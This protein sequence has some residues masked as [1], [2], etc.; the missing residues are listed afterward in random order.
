MKKKYIII[1]I[2]VIICSLVVVFTTKKG[3]NKGK[4]NFQSIVWECSEIQTDS[5]KLKS[6]ISDYRIVP[7]EY[8]DNS[9][10]GNIDKVIV[11]DSLVFIMDSQVA[12]G[13]FVFDVRSGKFI[14]NIGDVGKGFGEYFRLYD[15]SIDSKNRYI[16][17]LCEKKRLLCY[18]FSGKC[19]SVKELPFL[20][21]NF[22]YLDDKFYFINEIPDE[23]NLYITDCDFHIL[24]S[25]FPNNVYGENYRRLIHPLQKTSDG[26]LYRR[27]LDQNIYMID[28]DNN[29][30]PLYTLNLGDD[31]L[32]VD[33]VKKMPRGQLKDLMSQGVCHI[34]YYTDGKDYSMALFFIKNVPYISIYNKKKNVTKTYEYSM[35]KND[36]MNLDFPLLEFVSSEKKFIAVL[37]NED[38]EALIENNLYDNNTYEQNDNP[39][40][41]IFQ[42]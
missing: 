28:R 34:K 27:F 25:E 23:N 1:S 29:I 22:E 33:M 42:Q 7:L 9:I 37:Y 30:Y 14:R 41:C 13:I 17:V 38:I 19:L 12:A 32:S 35:M 36:L 15:M 2:L 21:T 39:M 18:S 5:F 26:I 24:S 11:A 8:T 31:Q 40:L 4:T 3:N 10:I 20:A 6:I 16:Y